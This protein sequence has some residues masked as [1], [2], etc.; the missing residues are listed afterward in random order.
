MHRADFFPKDPPDKKRSSLHGSWDLAQLAVF[1][2]SIQLPQP[3]IRLNQ[4][5]V[6][7]DLP[8]FI[9]GHLAILH[10]YNGNPTF[11][12]YLYRI[13]KLKHILENSD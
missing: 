9:S 8:K 12:P 5:T 4:C 10:K 13:Q 3:P 2:A 11:L 7:H 6:L 1:F